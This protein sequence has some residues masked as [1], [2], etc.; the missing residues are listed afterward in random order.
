M[1]ALTK[2]TACRGAVVAARWHSPCCRQGAMAEDQR[3]D[4]DMY[5]M[6]VCD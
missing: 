2:S 3:E 4:E 5:D 6:A 1:E